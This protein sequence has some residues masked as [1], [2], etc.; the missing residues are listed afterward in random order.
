MQS[1]TISSTGYQLMLTPLI[2]QL[3]QISKLA[4]YKRDGVWIVG[5]DSFWQLQHDDYAIDL[6]DSSVD[7]CVFTFAADAQLASNHGAYRLDSQ[8][9]SVGYSKH[10]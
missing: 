8:V 7:L 10:F 4:R 5:G 3:E 6:S 9:R 2:V 1:D